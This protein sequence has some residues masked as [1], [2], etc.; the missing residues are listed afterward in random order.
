MADLGATDRL[1]LARQ[2]EGRNIEQALS[3][4]RRIAALLTGDQTI[5]DLTAARAATLESI[6]NIDYLPRPPDHQRLQ[7]ARIKN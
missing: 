5:D 6:E 1:A 2:L 7:Y 3:R 4:L